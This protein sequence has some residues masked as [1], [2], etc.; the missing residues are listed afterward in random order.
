MDAWNLL[1]T[2]F[3]DA[4]TP[5]NLLLC[6]VGV[7]LGTAVG[8]LP[9]LGSSMAVAMRPARRNSSSSRSNAREMKIESRAKP[10]VVVKICASTML[11]PVVAQAPVTMASRRG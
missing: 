10:S 9:G 7:V 11:P 8:V 3:A 5:V 2:G 4:L 1:L 6:F